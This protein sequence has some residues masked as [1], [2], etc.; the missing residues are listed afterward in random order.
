LATHYKKF[1][2]EIRAFSYSSD[3]N[4]LTKS[5]SNDIYTASHKHA[6]ASLSSSAIYSYD[7]NGNPADASG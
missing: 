4:L 5:T 1:D 6:V 3:N 2:E 7:E